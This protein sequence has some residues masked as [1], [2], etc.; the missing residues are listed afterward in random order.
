VSNGVKYNR[1]NGRL[2]IHARRQEDQLL[3]SVADTGYG[4]APED[5]PHLFERFYRIP[6][7]EGQAEGSGLGLAI[8]QKLVEEHG[9]QIEVQSEAGSGTTFTIHLPLR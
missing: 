4:I 3:L 1:E 7:Q 5:L 2:T 8:T 6:S 9:G